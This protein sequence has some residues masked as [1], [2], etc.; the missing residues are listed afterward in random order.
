VKVFVSEAS[1]VSGFSFCFG[2]PEQDSRSRTE[3]KISYD[4]SQTSDDVLLI[5][6]ASNVVK[7]GSDIEID[8][9]SVMKSTT[10]FA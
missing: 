6:R 9:S 1:V 8:K 2:G 3:E 5:F 10:R 7:S 4:W